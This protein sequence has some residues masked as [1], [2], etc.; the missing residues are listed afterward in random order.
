[1]VFDEIYALS[2]FGDRPFTSCAT[3]L[4]SLGEHVHIV[5]AFSK[6]F[7]A[8]GLRCGVLVSENEA[9]NRAVDYYLY[10]RNKQRLLDLK[11]KLSL[12]N[13]WEETREMELREE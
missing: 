4:P 3:V 12:R 8:S 10:C 7:G 5:W 6:D 2:V 11:G 13:N 1:V 9:V